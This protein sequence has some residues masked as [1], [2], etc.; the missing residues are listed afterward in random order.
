M[1][2][3][4]PADETAAPKNENPEAADRCKL[5]E[6]FPREKRR[7]FRRYRGEDPAPVSAEEDASI[8]DDPHIAN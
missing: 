7:R 2:D 3:K 5:P 6:P 8:T 1:T 4:P